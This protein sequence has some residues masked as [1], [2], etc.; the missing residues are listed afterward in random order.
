MDI[1]QD[2]VTVKQLAT[3]WKVTELTVWRTSSRHADILKP[4]KIGGKLLF[5][6]DDIQKYEASRRV[7]K[8]QNTRN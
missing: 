2:L 5:E 4:M 1:N 8:S 6:P 3:R 7:I